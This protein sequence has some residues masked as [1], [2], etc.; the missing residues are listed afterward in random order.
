MYTSSNIPVLNVHL[1][2]WVP[3]F[4]HQIMS[5]FKHN[6]YRYDICSRLTV[7]QLKR[8]LK[9]KKSKSLDCRYSHPNRTLNEYYTGK[10][11]CLKMK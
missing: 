7:T 6:Y 3:G 8:N 2:G 5:D 11:Y 4:L 1:M 10:Y 9:N